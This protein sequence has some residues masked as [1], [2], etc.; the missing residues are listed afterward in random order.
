MAAWCLKKRY[1]HLQV[2]GRSTEQIIHSNVAAVT[3]FVA[4]CR[5]FTLVIH[6]NA[7]GVETDVMLVAVTFIL[8]HAEQ[9]SIFHLQPELAVLVL[10]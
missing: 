3:R 9:H 5:L 1:L 8:G 2:L 4:R 10:Y 6:A 7:A